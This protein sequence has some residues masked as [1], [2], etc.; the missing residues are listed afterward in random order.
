MI[1]KDSALNL[2]NNHAIKNNNIKFYCILTTG[3]A[4]FTIITNNNSI[5]L[6]KRFTLLLIHKTEVIHLEG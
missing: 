6:T 4:L 3:Q 2:D 1:P 5:M